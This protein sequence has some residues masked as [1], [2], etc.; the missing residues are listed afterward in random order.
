MGPLDLCKMTILCVENN[1]LIAEDLYKTLSN[2][3]PQH[4]ILMAE[5]CL[6]AINCIKYCSP[7]IYII[8]LD[9]SNEDSL[10]ILSVICELRL[11]KQCIATSSCIE[12]E[13]L[14]KYAETG[15]RCFITKPI[16]PEKLFQK[17]DDLMQFRFLCK[18]NTV[19]TVNSAMRTRVLRAL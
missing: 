9:I 18:F 8:S 5:D 16:V 7:D 6:T 17:I 12:T 10:F 1:R 11:A 14:A 3:Y 13:T 15:I 2:K 19:K 4:S